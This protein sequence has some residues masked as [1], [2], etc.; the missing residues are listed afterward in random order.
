[1]NRPTFLL[2]FLKCS[3][4]AYNYSLHTNILKHRNAKCILGYLSPKSTQFKNASRTLP[5]FSSV[6]DLMHTLNWISTWATTDDVSQ[7]RKYTSTEK[8]ANWGTESGDGIME[9]VWFD[10]YFTFMAFS[11][12][13]DPERLTWLIQFICICTALNHSYSL[14]V[15]NMAY[16]NDADLR[17]REW[18]Q[19]A[20]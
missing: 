1:M 15:L 8:N 5:G 3:Y 20:T 7:D 18:E 13:F 6:L 17:W 19:A 12:R 9:D 14:K 10:G 16:I 4:I 11:R 2:Y